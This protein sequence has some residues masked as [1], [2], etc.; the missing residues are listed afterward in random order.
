ME[1]DSSAAA[2]AGGPERRSAASQ[3]VHLQWR[4]RT[5]ALD[6]RSLFEKKEG[7]SA[8]A[9]DA[10]FSNVITSHGSLMLPPTPTPLILF[11]FGTCILRV[12]GV[13]GLFVSVTFL[14]HAKINNGYTSTINLKTTRAQD[15]L[16]HWKNLFGN[17][18]VDD[19][20]MNEGREENEG[21]N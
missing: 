2:R 14:I 9:Y 1:T 20:V 7:G 15:L 21:V 5:V 3:H 17:A 4:S 19:S 16:M 13:T 8:R 10:T 11:N 18:A 6:Q 12:C